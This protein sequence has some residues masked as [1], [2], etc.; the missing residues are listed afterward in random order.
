MQD[1]RSL[2]TSVTETNNPST[3]KIRFDCGLD[4]DG[5]S[6]IKSRSFSNV[7]HDA[8]ALDVLNVAQT[9]ES[10]QQHM[11]LTVVKQ[12]NTELN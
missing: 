12:D 7:K 10:L 8:A 3:L 5:K 4:N 1:N 11:I 9:L 6:I 2:S